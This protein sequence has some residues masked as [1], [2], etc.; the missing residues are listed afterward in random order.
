MSTAMPDRSLSDVPEPALRRRHLRALFRRHHKRLTRKLAKQEAELTE[1]GDHVHLQQIGDSL[2]A[3]LGSVPRNVSTCTITN[4]HTNAEESVRLNPK[5]DARRN[6]ELYFRKARKGRR[7]L[8]VVRANV[9]ATR[10]EAGQ[11]QE[12]LQRVEGPATDGGDEA[13]TAEVLEGLEREARTL[14]LLPAGTEVERRKADEQGGPY[15][16]VRFLDTD[17]YIGR[18][19][20]QN[21]ELTTRFAR[22]WDIWLHVG[23]HA[24][25]HVVIRREKAAPWPPKQVIA[26]AA[27]LAVWFS[28]ARHT[29]WADVHVAERRYVTKRRHAAAGEVQIREYKTVRAAPVSPQALLKQLGTG[30]T[31]HAEHT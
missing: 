27:G 11:V 25:S 3:A 29:S 17:V 6:A 9:T 24:G 31:V 7:A 18:S 26:A 10:K 8:E 20:M 5:F 23:V 12:L 15:R 28:K 30:G 22:P 21:D 1:A 19:D 4:V 16:H 2:L 13:G 14:G